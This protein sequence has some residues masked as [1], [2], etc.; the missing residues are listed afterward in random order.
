MPCTLIWNPNQLFMPVCSLSCSLNAQDWAPLMGDSAGRDE[1][2]KET[3]HGH[4]ETNVSG[5]EPP[6]CYLGLEKL[7][8][9]G[10]GR[11]RWT[12]CSD[13]ISSVPELFSRGLSC[14]YSFVLLVFG[15]YHKERLM[16]RD[17]TKWKGASLFAV[18]SRVVDLLEKSLHPWHSRW[19]GDISWVT[20]TWTCERHEALEWELRGFAPREWVLV[21]ES[22]RLGVFFSFQF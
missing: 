11:L 3:V 8:L 4:M 21:V 6:S 18:S 14:I 1:K 10:I 20:H 15:V 12:T 5:S 13:V 22:V 17:I 2:G 9:A 16:G 19:W 7:C